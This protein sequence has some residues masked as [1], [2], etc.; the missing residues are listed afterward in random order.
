MSY[1]H[2]PRLVFSGDFLSDV[3]TVNN[4]PAHYN[5][6]T[7]EPSFQEPAKKG[8]PGSN[9]WWNPEGGAVFDFRNCTVK[10]YVLEDGTECTDDDGLVGQL[11]KGADGRATGKMVDLDPQQQSCSELWSVTLRILTKDDELLLQGDITVTGFRDLQYRQHAGIAVNGQP[12]GATWTSVL[13]NLV[14]GDKSNE[15][16]F[17]KQLKAKTESDKL[18]VN[19]NGFG[20]YYNHAPDGRF[21]LGRLIGAIGP[22]FQGEPDTFPAG[23]RLYGINKQNGVVY[24]SNT[25]F[26]YDKKSKRLSFD[27]GASFPVAD[28]LGTISYKQK[29]VVGVAKGAFNSLPSASAAIIDPK[30]FVTIGQVD[31]QTGTE[32]LMNTGGIVSFDDMSKKAGKLLKDHAAL[33]ITVN[34]D[35]DY[36]V[37][38][39]ESLGGYNARADNYVQRIDYG[40]T[41]VVNFFAYQWGLPLANKHISISLQPPTPI[42]PVGPGNP[43]SELPGNNYPVDGLRFQRSI[44]T[45][46]N[47]AASMTIKGKRINNPRVYID[48]QIYFMDYELLGIGNDPGNATLAPDNVSVHLRDYFEV[49]DRPTWDDISET[50]TQ[51][52]NLYPIMSK[53][54]VDL[55]DPEALIQKKEIITF[56]FSR[57][58]NDP[59]YMPATRDLSETKKETILKWL[60]N[61]VL[62]KTAVTGVSESIVPKALEPSPASEGQ[63]PTPNQ[64]KIKLAMRA[65]SG[66][67]INF[68]DTETLKF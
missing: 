22:W 60:K 32:W 37:I 42:T 33:L 57:D 10:N 24:F 26:L 51:F 39:R 6:K 17:F 8:D 48:G 43:I 59:I 27:F 67:S 15:H 23:R 34:D 4:D 36:V 28:S 25:N 7:F 19:L 1:L 55:K 21:S 49:P 41:N 11:V 29:L 52:S 5:N 13:T 38:A 68:N 45:D 54:L 53:Y 40:Q 56:A 50:M 2:T 30:D 16:T 35:G 44:L 14:W 9:G 46:K 64:E 20:Y 65:K 3:S 58:I 62:P 47:G 63:K 66:K 31:Y 18:S 12:L 61:P